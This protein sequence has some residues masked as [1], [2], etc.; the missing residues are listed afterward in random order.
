MPSMHLRR[1]ATRIGRCWIKSPTISIRSVERRRATATSS[2]QHL[3]LSVVTRPSA[4]AHLPYHVFNVS[5]AAAERV[6]R[7]VFSADNCRAA[8]AL[9]LIPLPSDDGRSTTKL[10]GSVKPLALAPNASARAFFLL[11]PIDYSRTGAQARMKSSP[12]ATA[13]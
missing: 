12:R 5:R 11:N 3:I 8:R 9:L 6:Q 10:V 2:K 4:P 1:P 13:R 7:E